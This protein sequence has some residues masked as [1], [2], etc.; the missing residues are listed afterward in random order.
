M[1]SDSEGAKG[2]LLGWWSASTFDP[3]GDNIL[4]YMHTHTHT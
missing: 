4:V 1:H 3:A 2:K